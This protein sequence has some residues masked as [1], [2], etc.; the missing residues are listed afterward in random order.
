MFP[1]IERLFVVM[2]GVDTT[3]VTGALTEKFP[4]PKLI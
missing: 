1:K 3:V 2:F 4:P